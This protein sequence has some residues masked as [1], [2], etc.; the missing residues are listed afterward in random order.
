MGEEDL[1]VEPLREVLQ[2][3]QGDE[4]GG[5]VVVEAG[6][7]LL[8]PGLLRVGDV[9]AEEHRPLTLPLD[10]QR[11]VA[12]RVAGRVQEPDAVGE[13]DLLSLQPAVGG[14]GSV[15]NLVRVAEPLERFRHEAVAELVLADP[16]DGLRQVPLAATVIKVEV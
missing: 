13:V 2:L 6:D 14:V 3:A 16:G 9:G 4:V 10:H 15:E 11:V 12:H 5:G 8:L 7:Q 1:G